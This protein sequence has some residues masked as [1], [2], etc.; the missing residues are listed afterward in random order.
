M[1]EPTARTVRALREDFRSRTLR[2]EDL[3]RTTLSAIDASDAGEA[4][5]NA[6]ISRGGAQLEEQAAALDR[7][8]YSGDELRPLAGIPVAIK[9]NT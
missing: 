6:F 8:F 1:A 9:D 7:G 5:I 3:L 2:V 4:P